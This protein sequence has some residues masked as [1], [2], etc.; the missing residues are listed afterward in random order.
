M[1]A[2]VTAEVAGEG[3]EEAAGE[4]PGTRRGTPSPG[5]ARLQLVIA[6]ALFSTGGAAVKATAMGAWQVASFRS[7]IA[8][9]T[10]LALLPA[11]RRGYSLRA[12]GVGFAF[13]G[14]MVLFVLANKMTTAANAIFLQGTAPLYILLLAPLLLREPNKRRDL[15]F[16]ALIAAGLALFF[17][18]GEAPSDS[19]P[20][21]GLGNLLGAACGVCWG[22]TMLGLRGLSRREGRT[23]LAPV[24]LGNTIACL[25]CLPMALPVA[26]GMAT[27]PDILL[28][29]YLGAVQIGLA[30]VLVTA[31]I[32]YVPALEASLLLMIEPTFNPVWA[33][34]IH[35][36]VPGTWA[37][38]GGTLVLGATLG[39]SLVDQRSP[40]GT[41]RARNGGRTR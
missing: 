25:V 34:M 40:A 17:I 36:E 28:L 19:A 16:M 6:A 32:K 14:T 3:T 31:G 22:A 10:L 35:G 8:A 29:I 5:I 20:D 18:G 9:L 26:E 41:M 13:A 30:Y 27:T 12:L 7:G 11:A 23:N 1:S 39:K 21:P 4:Q 37:L 33:W 15:W 24:V 38:V 2:E